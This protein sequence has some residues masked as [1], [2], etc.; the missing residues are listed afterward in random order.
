[1]NLN[2]RKLKLAPIDGADV[3]A[4]L[5]LRLRELDARR[6]IITEE[7]IGLEKT[8]GAA[9]FDAG[10]DV[11]QAEALLNGAG[12]IPSRDKPV[13]QLA[14]LHAEREVIDRALKIG[15]DRQHRLATEQAGQIW[16]DYFPQIAE[17]EKR[18][19]LL[20]L[21]LQR[22]NR[23]RETFREKIT[24]AGGAGFLPSD[25]VE[26]LGLG[27]RDDEVRW[28]TE[29]LIADGI[30]TRAEI[31]RAKNGRFHSRHSAQKSL[32][33]AGKWHPWRQQDSF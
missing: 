7:I 18:R 11:A 6:A 32:L 12:Y 27:D 30:A 20:A 28:A 15:R 25:S 3:L 13:S 19:V 23:A 17:I 9:R 16:A 5:D 21:D 24:K 4:V 10:V 33:G 1:M 26:I 14:A 8:A 31:E 29:R 2:S 22:V